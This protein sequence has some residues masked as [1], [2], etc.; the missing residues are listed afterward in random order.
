M[1]RFWKGSIPSG[2]R[3][4]AAGSVDLLIF[5]D[6][7]GP[8]QVK[9]VWNA[10]LK[11]LGLYV[12]CGGVRETDAEWEEAQDLLWRQPNG[13]PYTQEQYGWAYGDIQK[14]AVSWALE[15]VIPHVQ[16]ALVQVP[17]GTYRWIFV[18]NCIGQHPTLFVPNVPPDYSDSGY[19]DATLAILQ[20]IRTTFPSMKILPNGWQGWAPI[21]Y[22][23][24][25]L[26]ATSPNYADGIYFEGMLYDVEG[27]YQGDPRFIQDQGT[28]MSMLRAGKVCIWDDPG[29]GYGTPERRR[30]LGYFLGT[31]SVSIN[32]G[33]AY[34]AHSEARWADWIRGI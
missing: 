31:T 2:Q 20:L 7:T 8:S 9:E 22:R 12:K 5:G 13:Q 11:E 32:P 4:S 10:G 24:E 3:A 33:N 6:G 16:A 1:N 29:A 25:A 18:D 21:G 19:H 26:G 27:N 15:V 28:L 30:S 23:G 34:F 14:Y 17:E